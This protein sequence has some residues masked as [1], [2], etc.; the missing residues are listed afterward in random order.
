MQSRI[1]TWAKKG[2]KKDKLWES[3]KNA[4]KREGV[5]V[6]VEDDDSISS[7]NGCHAKSD[8]DCKQGKEGAEVLRNGALKPAKPKK[9]KTEREKERL[10]KILDQVIRTSND[11]KTGM[12]VL[13]WREKLL[14]LATERAEN[15]G[16]CGW[17]QRLCYGDEEWADHSQSVFDSYEDKGDGDMDVDGQSES[18][19]GEWWC[20]EEAACSRHLGYAF[21]LCCLNFR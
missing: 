21:F 17:D 7:L 3:V 19:E 12:G 8:P 1:D 10:T 2:G 4:E 5:V 13:A 14:E 11:L 20:A 18:G 6:R 15:V 9:I 16:L